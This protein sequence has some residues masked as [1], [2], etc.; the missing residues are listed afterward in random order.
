[1]Q[2]WPTSD[3]IEISLAHGSIA[4]KAGHINYTTIR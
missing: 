2:P 1:M 4:D 3:G